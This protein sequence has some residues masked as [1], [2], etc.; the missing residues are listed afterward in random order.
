MAWIYSIIVYWDTHQSKT[1]LTGQCVVWV[2]LPVKGWTLSNLN[3]GT[4]QVLL[5][6]H[7]RTQDLRKGLLGT[8]QD[9]LTFTPQ[10]LVPQC[11]WTGTSVTRL[12]VTS[13]CT[14]KGKIKSLQGHQQ[15]CS[16]HSRE[17]HSNT[18]HGLGW[19]RLVP[20][21]LLWTDLNLLCCLTKP[22][23][24]RNRTGR[25]RVSHQEIQTA[26]VKWVWQPPDQ[27]GKM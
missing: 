21:L 8:A 15:L 4:Y 10:G 1:W 16:V 7:R 26:K 13:K 5:G 27:D 20:L 3:Q 25:G 6:S 22:V 17:G 12:A 19:A 23:W 18:S 24:P 11:P 9:M 2:W 14:A